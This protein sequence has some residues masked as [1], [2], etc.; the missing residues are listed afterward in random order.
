MEL[1][2][3]NV[4]R[5]VFL[6]NSAS[7]VLTE[8]RAWKIAPA[9]AVGCTIVMKPSEITPLTALVRPLVGHHRRW[10]SDLFHARNFLNSSKRL[11]MAWL[12]LF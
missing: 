2:H 1:S 8:S 4:V 5:R 3:W 6:T 11:G 10:F 9:L 12:R 7:T